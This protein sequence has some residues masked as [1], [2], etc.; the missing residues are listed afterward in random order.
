MTRSQKFLHMTWAPV[1]GNNRYARPSQF[2]E[3]VLVSK[4]V[5]RRRPDYTARPRMSPQ[6]RAGVA[7]VVFSFSNLKYFF[8]CPY[9]FKLRVLYGF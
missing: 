8:E 6:P 5:K 1:P 2:W 7:N 3:D 4:L 9:Q